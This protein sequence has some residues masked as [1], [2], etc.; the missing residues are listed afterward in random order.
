MTKNFELASKLGAKIHI[1]CK[2][3]SLEITM[4]EPQLDAF[5]DTIRADQRHLNLGE[6]C[7]KVFGYAVPVVDP[8]PTAEA[9]KE[10]VEEYAN[11]MACEAT[12]T[13]DAWPGIKEVQ[14][15]LYDAIDS[16]V[17]RV[18]EQAS[19]IARLTAERDEALTQRKSGAQVSPVPLTDAQILH[20]YKSTPD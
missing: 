13:T 17:Q 11:E 9:L 12:S 6:A 1:L 2:D 16:L 8:T 3:G 4:A 7:G 10:M 18:T 20:L 14:E 15:K 5:A 19:E